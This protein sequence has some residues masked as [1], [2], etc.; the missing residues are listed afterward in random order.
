M[1]L[2]DEEMA[3]NDQKPQMQEG[4]GPVNVNVE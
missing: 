3:S 2:T 1:S 4:E